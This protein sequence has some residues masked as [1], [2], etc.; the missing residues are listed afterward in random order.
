MAN[1]ND[2]PALKIEYISV[3]ELTPYAKNTRKHGKEDVAEIVK[4]I[5]KYGFDDPIGIWSDHNIIV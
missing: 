5:E 2:N 3:D 1:K 4:S